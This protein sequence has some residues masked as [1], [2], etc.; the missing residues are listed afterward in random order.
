MKKNIFA[1]LLVA[2]FMS[3]CTGDFLDKSPSDQVT[4]KEA[5]TTLS[6]VKNAVNGLYSLI[7]SVYYY[8]LSM[9]LYGDVKGD[10]MQ[11]T[12]WSGGRQGYYF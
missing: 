5:I 4:T 11:P 2:L 10:C 6:D 8:D 7:A 3:S 1:A 9:F 12:S